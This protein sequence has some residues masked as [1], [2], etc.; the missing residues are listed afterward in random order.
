[1]NWKGLFDSLALVDWDKVA[2]AFEESREHIKEALN[3]VDKEK[4]G[5]AL[6]PPIE[7]IKI[8]R[9]SMTDEKYWKLC[10]LKEV[11]IQFLENWGD[12]PKIKELNEKMMD[13][14][15]ELI[16]EMKKEEADE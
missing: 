16:E 7:A 6:V 2:E 11:F 9:N 8:D 12:K 1:M 13:M 15:N 10:A 14:Q 3:A 5:K 4:L